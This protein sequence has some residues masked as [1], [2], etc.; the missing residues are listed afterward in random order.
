MRPPQSAWLVLVLSA[1]WLCAAADPPQH[2]Q[3]RYQDS[4]AKDELKRQQGAWSV[5]SSIYDGQ[6]AAPELVSSIRRTVTDDRVVWELNGK[7]FAGSKIALDS[8]REPKTI[9]VIPDEGPNRGEHVLGIYR[10]ENDTLT[11]C[12]A[13]PGKPRPST[14]EA[15]KGSGCTLRTYPR[16]PPSTR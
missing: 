4:N 9:D 5:T 10:L 16:A 1:F 7:R 6:R 12:M 8:T 3:E 14:F 13:A 2:D 11:I 15:E